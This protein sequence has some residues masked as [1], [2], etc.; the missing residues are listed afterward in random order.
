LGRVGRPLVIGVLGTSM[1]S[2]KTTTVA[3]IVR[4]LTKAGFVVAAG[5][6]T[7]TGAG[8]DPMLFRDSGASRVLDFTDFGYGSTYRLEHQQVRAL[9]VSLIDEL[10]AAGPDVV[11]V[12]IA[13]GLFQTET[14]RLVADPVFKA[15]VDKV[16]FAAGEALGATSGQMLLALLGLP[17]VAVSGMLTASPLAKREAADSLVVP[18]LD[19]DELA[20]ASVADLLIPGYVGNIMSGSRTRDRVAG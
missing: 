12:E 14:A 6:V 7:G 11:V 5:K 16:V 17:P 15:H 13:D 1:N 20:S 10:A 4:G 19:K 3:S 18:V 9:L 8:G 2:G